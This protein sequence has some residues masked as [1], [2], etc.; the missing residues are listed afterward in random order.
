MSDVD[1]RTPLLENDACKADLIYERFSKSK[2][3]LIVAIVS[4]GGLV[5]CECVPFGLS[6]TLLRLNFATTFGEIS[7]HFR[8]LYS[9]YTPNCKG[10]EHDRRSCEVRPWKS[11]VIPNF[12]NL[13]I[14][15]SPLQ[16]CCQY[17]Y[18]CRSFWFLDWFL[19]RNIL[20]APLSPF[21]LSTSLTYHSDGRRPAYLYSLPIMIIGS[22]GVA[23]AQTI[24]QL[25]AFRFLQAMGGSPGTSVGFGVIGDIYRLEER[26]RA[27]GSYYGVSLHSWNR[28]VCPNRIPLHFSRR[29]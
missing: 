22:L 23:R 3:R 11:S 20:Y 15:S 9:I 24:H 18:F 29:H 27:M 14:Y 28:C 12:R 10:I 7:F 1:E 19:L 17:L 16:F 5:P 21:S 25:L 8:Y 2:K 26:G 13:D 6:D 4:W